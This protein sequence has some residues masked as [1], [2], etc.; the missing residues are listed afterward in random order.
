MKIVQINATCGIGSTGRTT[1]ELAEYLEQNGH[2]AHVFY[3]TGT[4][5]FAN[6]TLIGSKVGQKIHALLSRISGK[7]AYFSRPSTRKMLRQK[8]KLLKKKLNN[9]IRHKD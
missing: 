8:R 1:V 3:A 7:Q 5:S 4:S 9:S 6:S 2:Q